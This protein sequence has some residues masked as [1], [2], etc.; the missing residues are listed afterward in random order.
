MPEA[1]ARECRCSPSAQVSKNWCRRRGICALRSR[2]SFF[3]FARGARMR[4]SGATLEFKSESRALIRVTQ[5]SRK[6]GV[7]FRIDPDPDIPDVRF[8]K[9]AHR[10]GFTRVGWAPVR[11]GFTPAGGRLFQDDE[12]F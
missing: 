1:T 2:I 7:V 12:A 3:A 8:E 5:N 6:A 10:R 9:G 4:S 11:P